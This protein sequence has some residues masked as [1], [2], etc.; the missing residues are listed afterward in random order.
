MDLS[1]S[2]AELAKS[3]LKEKT[4]DCKVYIH[5]PSEGMQRWAVVLSIQLNGS[6]IQSSGAAKT[7]IEAYIKAIGS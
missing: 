7:K 4:S 2:L 5:P 3:L 6:V 1:H